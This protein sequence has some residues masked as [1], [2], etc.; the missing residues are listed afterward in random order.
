MDMRNAA[1]FRRA[2]SAAVGLCLLLAPVSAQEQDR[3]VELQSYRIPGWSF[4]PSVAIGAIYDTNIALASPTATTGETQGDTVLNIVP[5][6]QLRYLGK[7]TEFATSYGGFVRRYMDA[8]GLDEFAQRAALSFTRHVSKR[9][10]F[11]ARDSFNDSP[12]TDEIELNGVPFRRAGSRSNTFSA[13]T[14][15]KI[16]KLTLLS[17]RYDTTWVAFDQPDE[18][19]TGGWIHSIGNEFSRALTA[20]LS[21]GGEYRYRTASLN[22]GQRDFGFQDAGGVL[23]FVVGPHTSTSLAGGY[24]ML[25]DRNAD[26]THA[27]PYFRLGITHALERATVGAGFQRHYVPSFG[28]GGASSSQELN[29]Y[30]FMPVDRNRIYTQLS[31]TWRHTSPFEADAVE[32]DSI[33]LRSTIGYA[34]ARWARLEGQY[35]YTRQDSIITGGEVDRH[36]VGVQVVVSQPIRMR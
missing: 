6:G 3:A 22:E 7:Q 15:Y 16:S 29:G 25:D 13:A 10:T 11:L 9:L 23:R 20:R 1:T 21:L 34:V 8:D 4:T 17:T 2:G 35:T 24:S 26:E 12:T 30:V 31:A 32:L 19:L 14:E 33:W 27:G 5:A 18:F 28:F 36:R